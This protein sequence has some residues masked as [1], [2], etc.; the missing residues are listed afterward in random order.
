MLV[1]C[2][3]ICG[4]Y[5]VR[6]ADAYSRYGNDD[7]VWCAPS[8]NLGNAVAHNLN[9]SLGFYKCP[10]MVGYN[11]NKYISFVPLCK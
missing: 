6:C 11:I 1:L 7:P 9:I 10:I 4:R 8:F 2:T 5:V 3:F